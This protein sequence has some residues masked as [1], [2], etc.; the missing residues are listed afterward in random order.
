ML[1]VVYC[2]AIAVALRYFYNLAS[3]G[4][5]YWKGA[6]IVNC[7]LAVFVLF[8]HRK[9]IFKTNK[10][11]NK[12]QNLFDYSPLIFLVGCLLLSLFGDIRGRAGFTTLAN[13][14]WIWIFFIPVVEELTF[15]VGFGEYFR[16]KLGL[17]WGTYFSIL[18][19][20]LA[21][22]IGTYFYSPLKW[23]TAIPLGVFL[24]GLCCEL[25][26]I[27]RQKVATIILFHM[28]ANFSIVLFKWANVPFM[29]W[30]TL[31]YSK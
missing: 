22:T 5:E 12:W 30:L 25:L 26:W 27:G 19:F 3:A 4:D 31:L 11:K 18:L 14:N 21:H 9:L 15:R 29:S 2:I 7:I 28:V 1:G 17:R 23:F 6:A 16:K 24:L 20:C 13:E 10:A 8:I